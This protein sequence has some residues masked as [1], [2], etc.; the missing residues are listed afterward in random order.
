MRQFCICIHHNSGFCSERMSHFG[1]ISF[2]FNFWVVVIELHHYRRKKRTNCGHFSQRPTSIH[3]QMGVIEEK[4]ISGRNDQNL[5]LVNTVSRSYFMCWCVQ[6]LRL[7]RWSIDLLEVGRG[8]TAEYCDQSFICRQFVGN[9]LYTLSNVQH[10][11]H[12]SGLRMNYYLGRAKG[13]F[14][15]LTVSQK[16]HRFLFA[17]FVWNFL[18]IICDF[19]FASKR[20]FQWR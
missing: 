14:D 8:A 10:R 19:P 11:H 17:V 12:T 7:L 1:M 20:L 5:V 18:K 3:H 4:K 15:S 2:I 13:R 16:C 9:A 6:V